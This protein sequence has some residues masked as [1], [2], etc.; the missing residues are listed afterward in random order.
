MAKFRLTM[1]ELRPTPYRQ[2]SIIRT[3]MSVWN[4]RTERKGP[5]VQIKGFTL[6][7]QIILVVFSTNNPVCY[8]E[9]EFSLGCWTS[10]LK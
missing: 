6:K 4:A 3:D 9:K 2:D 1:S 10:T 5:L 8:D 7:D